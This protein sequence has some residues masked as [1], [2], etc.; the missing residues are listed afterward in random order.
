VRQ[1]AS[2]PHTV[3]T[4]DAVSDVAIDRSF[5]PVHRLASALPR[6]V[7]SRVSSLGYLLIVELF[8]WVGCAVVNHPMENLVHLAIAAT[9]VIAI[10]AYWILSGAKKVTKP[11]KL[12]TDDDFPATAS[13]RPPESPAAMG[14]TAASASAVSPNTARPVRRARR[15]D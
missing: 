11:R 12:K 5:A 3:D 1:H 9:V 4:S 13:Q 6:F 8:C 15:E 14:E 2:H 10:L 7:R